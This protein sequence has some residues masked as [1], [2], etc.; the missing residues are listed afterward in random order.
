MSIRVNEKLVAIEAR[1]EVGKL[2]SNRPY[3][4]LDLFERTAG[5]VAF[6]LVDDVTEVK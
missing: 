4:F 6:A 5:K 1:Y 3:L 2:A